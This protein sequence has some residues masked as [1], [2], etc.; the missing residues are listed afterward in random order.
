[1]EYRR[2]W[3]TMPFFS[4]GYTAD[5]VHDQDTLALG[6]MWILGPTE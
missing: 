1:V 2:D 3:S 5:L 6:M 4:R